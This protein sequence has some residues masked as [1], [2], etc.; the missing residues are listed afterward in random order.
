MLNHLLDKHGL[1]LEDLEINVKHECKYV[2]LPKH[3]DLFFALCW[4]V[5]PNWDGSYLRNRYDKTLLFV[6]L[7]NA[8]QLELTAKFDHYALDF[9][10]QYA[11]FLKDIKT[12][13]KLFCRAYINKQDIIVHK[14]TDTS[15]FK[16]S[17]ISLLEAMEIVGL[18]KRLREN[19]FN[20]ATKALNQ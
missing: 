18:S 1:T 13:R 9:D 15:G 5:I 12:Q 4:E 7:T 10:R 8:E 3:H 14:D 19:K 11:A 20:K 16:T 17:S 6:Q 2:I